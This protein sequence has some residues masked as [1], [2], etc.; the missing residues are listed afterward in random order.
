MKTFRLSIF[1][2]ANN[3]AIKEKMVQVSS[4]EELKT[5]KRIFKNEYKVWFS[6]PKN[7]MGVKRVK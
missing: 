5:Q 3:I 7:W 1:K 4:M 6:N 2:G